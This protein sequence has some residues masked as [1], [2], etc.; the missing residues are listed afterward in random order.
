LSPS[1]TAYSRV[2]FIVNRTVKRS[3]WRTA[4]ASG[5]PFTA[6]EAER[7]GRVATPSR[8]TSVPSMASRFPESCVFAGNP[9]YLGKRSVAARDFSR[10][11]S[12]IRIRYSSDAASWASKE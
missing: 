12:A 3:C 8:V 1:S 11:T 2:S 5:A 9:V 7:S 4:P 10:G 6:S